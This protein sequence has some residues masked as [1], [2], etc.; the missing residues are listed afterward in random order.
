MQPNSTIYGLLIAAYAKG[1]QWDD[2]IS[3][4]A[5]SCRYAGQRRRLCV[6]ILDS[7]PGIH[8]CTA[9]STQPVVISQLCK[10]SDDKNT[11]FVHVLLMYVTVCEPAMRWI[12]HASA[13]LIDFAAPSYAHCLCCSIIAHLS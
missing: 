12:A 9:D 7:H 1:G 2:A 4:L 3:I 11:A 5:Y 13:L 6:R 8:Y 10:D